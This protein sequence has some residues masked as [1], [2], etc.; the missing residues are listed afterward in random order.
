[1]DTKINTTGMKFNVKEDKKMKMKKKRK[2]KTKN[3][4]GN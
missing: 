3:K 2:K 4:E 1:M